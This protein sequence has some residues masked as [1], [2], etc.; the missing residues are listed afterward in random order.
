MD[1]PILSLITFV[2]LL[3]SLIV[4]LIPKERERF[5]KQFSIAVT[6][7]PLILSILLWINLEKGVIVNET[8]GRAGRFDPLPDFLLDILRDGG[9]VPHTVKRL[10]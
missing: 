2:P 7:I 5:I 6:L 9:L 8:T 10:H 1:F 4:L 3:G